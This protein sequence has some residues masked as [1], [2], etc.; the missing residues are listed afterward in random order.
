MTAQQP[1]DGGV[2]A[3]SRRRPNILSNGGTTAGVADSTE[4]EDLISF[5][6]RGDGAQTPDIRDQDVSQVL[7]RA[8]ELR[9]KSYAVGVELLPYYAI[10]VLTD[11]AGTVLGEAQRTLASMDVAAV[12]DAVAELVRELTEELVV[13]C[14]ARIAVGLHLAGPVDSRTGRV[15]FYG[16]HSPGDEASRPPFVWQ[17]VPLGGLIER[18]TGLPTAV[19]NDANAFALYQRWFGAGRDVDKFALVLVRDGVGGSLF[20]DGK[21]FDGPFEIGNLVVYPEGGRTCDCGNQGCLEV[22]AGGFGIAETAAVFADREISSAAQAAELAEEFSEAAHK[23]R[24]AFTAAGIAVAKALGFITTLVAPPRIILYGPSF[25]V[26]PGSK[27]ADAF[28]REAFG[29]KH[30]VSHDAFRGCELVVT[31]LR[32]YEGAQAAAIVALEN[33]L[34]VTSAQA[35][36]P[37]DRHTE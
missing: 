31:A 34:G 28:L 11:P 21:L 12:V 8:D 14:T 36:A 24:S 1:I 25:M 10:A 33:C 3:P 22:T 30:Y 35:R 32:P 26:E 15:H 2:P 4:L 29:F 23:V 13:T 20:A 5:A 27:A 19:E 7:H 6:L 17:E 37:R 16:K 9:E 18:A